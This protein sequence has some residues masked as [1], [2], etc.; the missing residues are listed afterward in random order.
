MLARRQFSK[1]KLS[2]K[3]GLLLGRLSRSF[4]RPK[5]KLEYVGAPTILACG[6]SPQLFHPNQASKCRV[7][8]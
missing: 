7:N 6:G 3:I 5:V 8:G 4:P 2:Q 1:R